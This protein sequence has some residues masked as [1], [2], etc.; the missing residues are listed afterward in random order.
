MSDPEGMSPKVCRMGGH[1]NPGYCSGPCDTTA[2]KG[3]FANFE[4]PSH[5]AAIYRRGQKVVIK[6]Q[7]NNHGPGGF[8]RH[9]LV[10]VS[11]MMSHDAHTRNAFAFSCFG[12]TPVVAT[13]EDRQVRNFGFSIVGNDGKTAPTGY[14]V[15]TVEIPD[16]VPDGDYVLGWVWYGGT[17]GGVSNTPYTEEPWWKGYFGDYW[18]CSFVRIQGGKPLASRYERVFDNDMPQF[19][20]EGCMS[21]NDAP[22]VCTWEPCI[23]YGRYQK[24]RE[25]T[26]EGGPGYLTR[27]NFVTG[28]LS[29]RSGGGDDDDEEEEYV[30]PDNNPPD[31]SGQPTRDL[32]FYRA[33]R[34][35]RCINESEACGRTVA[36]RTGGKC[37]AKTSYLEQSAGCVRS[38]CDLCRKG[39]EENKDLCIRIKVKEVCGFEGGVPEE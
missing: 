34:A 15:S 22:G 12:A 18:T 24:P 4:S 39:Y 10:P 9:S 37:E 25:F 14:Y 2:L 32:E 21:A 33:K 30:P 7:R 6:Y 28:G 19:S 3:R 26:Q 20:D 29:D 23:V 13:R 1:P 31:F 36:G 35:C 5:P 27:A 38:C 17:G 8:V 11:Q 16:V